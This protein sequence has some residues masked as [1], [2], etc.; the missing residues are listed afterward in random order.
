MNGPQPTE[1]PTRDFEKRFREL[2][3]EWNEL[4]KQLRDLPRSPGKQ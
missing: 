4:Q 1:P 2:E 3:Q